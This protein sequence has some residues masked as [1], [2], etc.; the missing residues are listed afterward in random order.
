[1]STHR[2]HGAADVGADAKGGCLHAHGSPFA[3][4]A[5]TAGKS[6]VVRASGC[7]EVRAC[8]K[9][10][11][12]LRVRRFCNQRD[13]SE[14]GVTELAEQSGCFEAVDDTH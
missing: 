1:M 10:H 11:E 8:L 14:C 6:W 13:L 7:S 9:V 5:A 3:A 2:S 12:R 4:R